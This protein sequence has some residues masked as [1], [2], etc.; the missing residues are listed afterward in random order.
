MP[1]VLPGTPKVPQARAKAAKS[2]Y[3]DFTLQRH[4]LGVEETSG[5]HALQS[6]HF[7]AGTSVI[8]G[9][10]PALLGTLSVLYPLT[11]LLP[12]SRAGLSI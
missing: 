8:E 11:R 2:T 6:D 12:P 7:R 9:P 5:L 10:D 3:M 4:Y 1:E